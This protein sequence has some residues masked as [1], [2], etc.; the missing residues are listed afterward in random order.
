MESSEVP[1]SCVFRL[2]WFPVPVG[3]RELSCLVDVLC[4]WSGR[5]KVENTIFVRVLPLFGNSALGF[6]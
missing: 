2:P 4:F 1:S 3:S 5:V 6:Y